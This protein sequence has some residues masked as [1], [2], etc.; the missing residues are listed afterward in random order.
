MEK[1]KKVTKPANPTRS[2]YS[3][4]GWYASAE[5]SDLFDWNK[6]ITSDTTAYARWAKKNLSYIVHYV[7]GD[8]NP[9]ASDKEVSNPNLAAG[10]VI[11]EMAI[12][13]AGYR[14]NESSKE[15]TLAEEENS[16]TFT[17]SEKAETTGYTVRYLINNEEFSG[18]IPVA[19]EKT[20]D[21]VP[22]DTSSVVEMAK[23]VNY[24]ALYSTHN[25]LK[26]MEKSGQI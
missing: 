3:F 8:G 25:I 23:S 24:T 26:A 6:Q 16:V 13:V 7:D 15:F 10:Q 19:A 9:V 12:A 14:P 5:G 20:V 18:D 22:G 1:Y 4:D 2:G 21:D 17:Y 11:T